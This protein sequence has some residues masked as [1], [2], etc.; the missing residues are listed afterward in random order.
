MKRGGW[1]SRLGLGGGLLA[2]GFLLSLFGASTARAGTPPSNDNIANATVIT[3]LPFN[4]SEDTTAATVA[5]SDPTLPCRQFAPAA[6]TVWFE[7]TPS[8]LGVLNVNTTGSNYDTVLSVWHGSPANHANAACDNDSG[9][10][11]ASLTTAV[12]RAGVKYYI[13][14][15]GF[16]T[17]GTGSGMLNL[18]AAF[19]PIHNLLV[20]PGFELDSNGDG[21][22]NGWVGRLSRTSAVVL[23]GSYAGLFKGTNDENLFAQQL[24]SNL[25]AGQTYYLSGNVYVPPTSD[26]FTFVFRVRWRNGSN[27]VLRTDMLPAVSGQT[28]G[29][30][31]KTGLW[32]APAGTTNALVQL[33]ALNLTGSIYVDDMAFGK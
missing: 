27:V 31:G 29:W 5:A 14:V 30:F 8:T 16:A 23:G 12:L 24:V 26:S 1:Q 18:A 9:G 20:N 3:T 21:H 22:P 28:N 2:L 4:T 33:V 19:T 25:T 15:A 6:E 7:Y 17:G 13:E 10:G 11:L 32:T